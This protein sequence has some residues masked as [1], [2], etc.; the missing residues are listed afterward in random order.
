LIDETGLRAEWGKAEGT[1]SVVYNLVKEPHLDAR[2]GLFE[3]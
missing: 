1:G 2:Q 3:V